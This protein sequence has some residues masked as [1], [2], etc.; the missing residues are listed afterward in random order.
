MG[1]GRGAIAD[2]GGRVASRRSSATGGRLVVRDLGDKCARDPGGGAGGGRT[3]PRR[4]RSTGVGVGCAAVRAVRVERGSVA[5]A[6]D[7]IS[8]VGG[9]GLRPEGGCGR[10]RGGAGAVATSGGGGFVDLG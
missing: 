2:T 4:L 6:S 3:R 8:R 5:G 10:T 9:V 7:P 1:S